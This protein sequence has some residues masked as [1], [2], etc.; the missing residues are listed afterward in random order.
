VHVRDVAQACLL[1]LETK[2]GLGE[3]FNVGSG[4][5][6]SVLS[7]ASDLA[8]VL[9]SRIS[10]HITGKYRAGDIR[11]C[12]ADI[13]KIESTLGFAPSIKFRDGLEELAGWLAGQIAEDRV[14]HATAELEARGL[15]A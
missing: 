9:G 2:Q 10:P 4:E 15:V 7:I 3:V 6:R 5:S 11:H 12:F 13:S 14:E 1:A 8:S